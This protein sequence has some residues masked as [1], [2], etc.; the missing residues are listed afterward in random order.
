MIRVAPLALLLASGG[1]V[2]DLEGYPSLAPRAAEAQSSLAPLPDETRPSSPAGPALA[3][4]LAAEVANARAALAATDAALARARPLLTAA[5]GAASDSEA[6]IAAQQ[7]LSRAET[8]LVP[9]TD[10]LASLDRIVVDL[11][12]TAARTPATPGLTEAI[13]ARARAAALHAQGVDRLEGA[14][15]A[16]R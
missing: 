13:A 16:L 7:A 1:C 12:V 10:A 6:W 15:A 8:A 14:R 5:R 3:A 11:R 4:E 9:A 2:P